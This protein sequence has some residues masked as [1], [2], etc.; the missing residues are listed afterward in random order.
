MVK[1]A[2]E[3]LEVALKAAQLWDMDA[4]RELAGV[5]VDLAAVDHELTDML[6]DQGPQVPLASLQQVIAETKPVLEAHLR[7]LLG[8]QRASEESARRRLAPRQQRIRAFVRAMR[9]DPKGGPTRWAAAVAPG[10]FGT[11]ARNVRSAERWFHR[12]RAKIQAA[13]AADADSPSDCQPVPPDP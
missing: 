4:W 6:L 7:V 5:V 1:A 13:L 12:H 11:E 3:A 10:N 9:S 8:R 2:L